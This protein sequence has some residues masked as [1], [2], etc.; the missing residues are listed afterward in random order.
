MSG[1]EEASLVVPCFN[2]E[3]RLRPEAFVSFV[4]RRPEIS[5][6]F[7]DDGSSD[8]TAEVLERMASERPDRIRAVRLPRNRGKAEAVR[9]GVLTAL[10][11][12]PDFFGYWD[13]DLATPLEA[14]P[15][16]LRV[17][18]ER[19]EVEI[20]MGARV[21]LLGRRIRRRR[22]RHY[23][24]RVFATLV[25]LLLDLPVYDT[26]CGA[27]LF[28]SV[29]RTRSVFSEPFSVGWI[30]D[31]EML[32]RY[33]GLVRADPAAP[34]PEATI[35]ELPLREWTDVEGSKTRPSDFLGAALDLAGIWLR[36]GRAEAVSEGTIPWKAGDS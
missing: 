9:R 32:A 13:A 36:Y 17:L 7:V 20:V 35:Y 28:R 3:A 30:F 18:R 34:S 8:G 23:P 19:P 31:V 1:P 2:E 29:S 22:A 25:S 12:E 11:D 33:V 10:E 5:F 14:L 21:R 16:F 24:G 4:E 15:E 6:V 27:K 26:Q